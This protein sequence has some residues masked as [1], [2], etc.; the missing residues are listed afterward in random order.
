MNKEGFTHLISLQDLLR[1]IQEFS[2]PLQSE[3]SLVV[4]AGLRILAE[5]IRSEIAVPSFAKSAM[6]GYAIR[7]EDSFHASASKRITLQ[8]IDHITPGIFSK[9]SVN[10]GEAIEISTGAPIPEGADAVVMVE[11]CEAK[12][13]DE[14]LVSRSVS[15]GE[16]VI[17]IGSDIQKDELV[18]SQGSLLNPAKIGVLSALGLHQVNVVKKPVI[19][20]AS[21]GDEL[22]EPNT[23]YVPGK[24]F[25]INRFTIQSA[26]EN[27]GCEVKSFGI[28]PDDPQQLRSTIQTMTEAGDLILLSGGSS[29]GT[30]DYMVEILASLGKIIAHGIAVKPGKPTMIGQIGQ[31]WVIG[32]PGHPT[33]ALSNFYLVIRPLIHRMQHRNPT[34]QPSVKGI[35]TRKIFSTIGRWEF[36]PV[37]LDLSAQIPAVTPLL[38]GSSAITSLSK[39]DG[40]IELPE[41]AE[42][43]EKGAEI[44]VMLFSS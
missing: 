40:F 16:N 8:V 42:I 23:P 43:L 28:I 36:I 20:I 30:S 11:Y 12:S 6:D 18:L 3:T 21:T 25:D 4:N 7:A 41:Y 13:P 35:L 29:L 39:A 24:V 38:T 14:I 33:S 26:C 34:I 27:E 17:S 32:L 15:P 2:F 1:I 44:N 31:K 5:D 19:C 37:S 9:K 22:L 10:Q